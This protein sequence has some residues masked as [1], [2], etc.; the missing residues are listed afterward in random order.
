MLWLSPDESSATLLSRVTSCGMRLLRVDYPPIL[1]LLVE[2]AIT[3]TTV[4]LLARHL[5]AENHRPVLEAARHKSKAEVQMIVAGLN[6]QPDV[7]SSV[8]K[9]AEPQPAVH[10][11][12]PERYKLQVTISAGTRAK[13][14]RAQDLLR[15]TDPDSDEAAVIDRALT[16]LVE[17]LERT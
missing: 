11:L 4:T 10:P 1:D 5:T 14:R 16:L 2:G 17:H 13:L 15:H 7:P 12:A 6:P 9:L 3:L 8:R